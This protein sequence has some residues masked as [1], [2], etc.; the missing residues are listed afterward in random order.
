M[1]ISIMLVFMAVPWFSLQCAFPGHA[2]L[3]LFTHFMEVLLSY[4]CRI[5]AEL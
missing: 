2:L 3:F 5:A 4:Y 1:T